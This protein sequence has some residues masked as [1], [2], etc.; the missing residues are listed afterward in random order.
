MTAVGHCWSS[1]LSENAEGRGEFLICQKFATFS[2][3]LGGRGEIGI[4]TM[5]HD[6]PCKPSE[7]PP[8]APQAAAYSPST[9]LAAKWTLSACWLFCRMKLTR[10]ILP[11]SL[12][13][14]EG[15]KEATS[16]NLLDP[17]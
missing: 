16:S 3:V 4:K 8:N 6:G 14:H 10:I 15:A 1:G 12:P 2:N 13:V 5:A 11:C 7:H 9:A 17:V